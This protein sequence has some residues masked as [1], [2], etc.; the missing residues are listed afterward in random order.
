MD[1]ESFENL[2]NQ[3]GE[4][5]DGDI[6]RMSLPDLSKAEL[7]INEKLCRIKKEL[8]GEISRYDNKLFVAVGL[9]LATQRN[10]D[11][12]DVNLSELQGLYQEILEFGRLAKVGTEEKS[13]LISIKNSVISA[14]SQINVKKETR[15][16]REI[17][18]AK[19]LEELKRAEEERKTAEYEA[20]LAEGRKKQTLQQAF[21]NGD[22]IPVDDSNQVYLP[23][24]TA[25][26]LGARS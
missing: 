8:S 16:M 11:E 3:M 26:R 19:Y 6:K 5:T 17:A 10:S 18:H 1:I 9:L 14:R 13:Y 22:F 25:K 2:V 24:S 15:K 20:L 12:F 4:I 7:I 23:S 21:A